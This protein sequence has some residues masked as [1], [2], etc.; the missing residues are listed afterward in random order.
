MGGYTGEVRGLS[1][2]DTYLRYVE[3]VE[4]FGATFQSHNPDPKY[5]KECRRRM[6][7][8]PHTGEWVLPF[9]LHT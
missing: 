9:H 6:I 8:D 2:I 4:G 5:K 7:Q 3:E 1:K